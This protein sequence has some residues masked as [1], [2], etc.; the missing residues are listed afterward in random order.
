MTMDGTE[1]GEK[2]L[3]L[4][5]LIMAAVIAVFVI[6]GAMTIFL[7]CYTAWRVSLDAISLQQD[8]TIVV[9]KMVRGEK[10]AG[11]TSRN[12]I[13]EA[14][15]FTIPTADTIQFIS[16][17]DGKERS[18]YLSGDKIMYDPDTSSGGDEIIIAEDV[19]S[20]NFTN[21]SARRVN[22]NMTMEKGLLD[23]KVNQGLETEVTIRN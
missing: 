15:S 18:F 2:G 1:H 23:R 3:T 21:P 17:L 4:P 10:A 11:E 19:K 12:G 22:I 5:E 7:T 14:T 20:L 16:G 13:R 6:A 9:E 8:G